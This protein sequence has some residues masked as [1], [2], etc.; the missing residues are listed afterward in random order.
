MFYPF[1]R[2][3]FSPSNI[4]G[5]QKNGP[6]K[7]TLTLFPFIIYL[8]TKCNVVFK[9]REIEIFSRDKYASLNS[10]EYPLF[11]DPPSPPLRSLG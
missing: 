10:F 6:R 11:L 3:V 5:T 8:R 1:Y 7:S 4:V 2:C 9:Y